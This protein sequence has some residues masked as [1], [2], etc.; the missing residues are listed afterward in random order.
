MSVCPSGCLFVRLPLNIEY[1]FCELQLGTG[2]SHTFFEVRGG[3]FQ[4]FRGGSELGIFFHKIALISA[5]SGLILTIFSSPATQ[6]I[7]ADACSCCCLL[8]Q[9]WFCIFVSIEREKK[10]YWINY[11]F[12]PMSLVS[13]SNDANIDILMVDFDYDAVNPM[14]TYPVLISKRLRKKENILNRK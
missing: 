13:T 14:Y 10:K 7:G 5:T 6:R 12:F 8:E 3:G 2:I 9:R 11:H 4:Y 1:N